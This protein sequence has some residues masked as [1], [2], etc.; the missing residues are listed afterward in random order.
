MFWGSSGS[1]FDPCLKFSSDGSLCRMYHNFNIYPAAYKPYELF[2][3]MN[4]ARNN[5]SAQNLEI[6]SERE[7]DNVC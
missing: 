3:C 6:E 5:C 1:R 7:S 4:N 2:I